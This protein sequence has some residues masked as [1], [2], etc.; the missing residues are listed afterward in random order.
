MQK[1]EDEIIAICS[2]VN[3]GNT[4]GIYVPCRKCGV[5]AWLS[6]STIDSIKLNHPEIN[7]VENPPVVLCI[8]CGIAHMNNSKSSVIIPPS[9][10]QLEEIKAGIENINARRK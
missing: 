1:E 3:S 9:K 10:K 6:D 5:D 2:N 4:I 8:A 7:I